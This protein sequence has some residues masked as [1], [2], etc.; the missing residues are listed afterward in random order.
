MVE[1][2]QKLFAVLVCYRHN[3]HMLHWKVIGLDFDCV[4]KLLD[5]YVS[6][7]NDFIDEIGE[8]ILSLGGN[9]LTLHECVDLVVKSD[10]HILNVESHESYTVVESFR[11]VGA[12]FATLMTSYEMLQHEDSLPSECKSKLDEHL[13]WLRI[14]CRYKNNSRLSSK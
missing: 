9:P 5:D 12:M 10:M 6:K 14:E 1:N 4:H 2:L 11:A 7:F 13:Y 8:M 3:L